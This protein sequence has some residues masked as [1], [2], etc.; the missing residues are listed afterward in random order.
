MCSGPSVDDGS[1]SW[2]CATI[3]PIAHS[4]KK[5]ASSSVRVPLCRSHDS[6]ATHPVVHT[7][8][9]RDS[10]PRIPGSWSSEAHTLDQAST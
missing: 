3:P 8:A 2:I 7:I 1:C 9:T 5:S 10:R 6:N 4:Q